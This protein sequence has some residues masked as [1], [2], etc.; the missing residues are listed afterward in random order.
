M[1]AKEVFGLLS[2]GELGKG[3]SGMIQDSD[4]QLGLENFAGGR[5]EDVDAVTVVDFHP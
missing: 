5:L 4:E 1:T 2:Q 3:I